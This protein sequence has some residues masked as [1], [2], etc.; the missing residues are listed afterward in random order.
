MTQQVIVPGAPSDNAVRRMSV[1][2]SLALA[3]SIQGLARFS[4]VRQRKGG[5]RDRSRED[6]D[7][8]PRSSHRDRALARRANGRPFTFEE[9]TDACGEVGDSDREGMLRRLG[10]SKRLSR[11]LA[12]LGESAELG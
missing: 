2:E 3:D 7:H 8:I 11:M 4:D 5:E 1:E 12:G 10:E 6:E 9:V